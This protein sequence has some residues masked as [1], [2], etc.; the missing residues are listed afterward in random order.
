MLGSGEQTQFTRLEASFFTHWAIL[1]FFRR[2]S[3]T[4]DYELVAHEGLSQVQEDSNLG[5]AED[6]KRLAGT[7]EQATLTPPP[8]RQLPLPALGPRA[9]CPDPPPITFRKPLASLGLG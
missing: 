2:A 7:G 1:P 5:A 6:N 9:A 4:Y 3:D 8:S